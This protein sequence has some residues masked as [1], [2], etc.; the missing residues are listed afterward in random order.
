MDLLE[1]ED[2]VIS[3]IGGFFPQCKNIEEFKQRL[4]NKEDL[5]TSR[6]KEGKEKY[7][8]LKELI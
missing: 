3:G 6:W 5:L 7:L 2:V 4:L 8:K 1:N